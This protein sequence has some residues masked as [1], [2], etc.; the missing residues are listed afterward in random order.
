M[1][2]IVLATDAAV[3]IA[4]TAAPSFAAGPQSQSANIQAYQELPGM[5][6]TGRHV[7][8]GVGR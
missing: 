4:L 1:K 2:K 7:E 3:V 8:P 6:G 5:W